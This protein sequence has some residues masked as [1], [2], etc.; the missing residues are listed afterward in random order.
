VVGVDSSATRVAEA[1]KRAEGLNLP[2]EFVVG[3][4]Q[5]LEFTDNTFDGCRAERIFVHLHDPAQ[6]L[7]EM[8]RV[9]RP[10]ARLVVGD[11]DFETLVVDVPERTITR[12]LLN[13]QC[14]SSGSRWIGRQ[15]RGFFL[16]A[17]L[18]EVGVLADTA[19]FTDYRQANQVFH[20]QETA[21]QAQVAGVVSPTEV[22]RWLTELEQA[23]QAG[24]FFAAITTFCVSGRKP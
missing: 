8:I 24:K 21:A 9:A 15:L 7:A 22:N 23:H 16:A 13:F 17:G 2:V 1:Q 19:M 20:L 12:K 10:G 18:T 3:E 11:P 14:D 6:A 5:R 4:A